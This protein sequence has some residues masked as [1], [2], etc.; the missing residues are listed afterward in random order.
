MTGKRIKKGLVLAAALVSL[1][2][3]TAL[4]AWAATRLDTVSDAWWDDDNVTVATWEEVEDAYQ[5][6][7]YLYCDESR[8]DTIKTKKLR[9][10]FERKMTKAGD[11]TFRV[12]ALAKNSS[13][14]YRDG[15][16]SDYSDSIYINED[17]AEL[18]KNGGRVDT[19][20]SG[21]GAAGGNSAVIPDGGVV[22]TAQWMQNEKGWWYRRADGT[23]P[24]N[25]WF[26]DPA[27]SRWYY[28][29][30]EGYMMT[31]WIEV[32]GHRYYCGADG[33]MQT[34]TCTIDGTDY[35]FDASGALLAG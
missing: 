26:Q 12:R 18:M 17:F 32:D 22:Y 14:D 9:Y 31:G 30:A 5:Y 23:F 15:Y 13:K 35:Q 28:F 7:V 3:G 21:P 2:A 33:A 16:W 34:G 25:S 4:T 1:V 29:N 27:N 6:E 10:D 20:N 11:Y 8:V 24:A 19:Q